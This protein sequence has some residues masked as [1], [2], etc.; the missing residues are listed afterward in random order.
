MPTGIQRTAKDV[1]DQAIRENKSVER[2]LYV[3]CSA[4]TGIGLF[5]LVLAAVQRQPIVA[6]ASSIP[7]SL[8]W[9]AIRFTK[10]T[11]KENIAL[12]LLEVPLSRAQTATAAAET[13]KH[14]FLDIFLGQRVTGPQAT[15]SKD[16]AGGEAASGESRI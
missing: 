9:P 8:L 12:R 6:L 1:I 11:R 13:L 15:D 10:D 16:L 7:I 5:V 14:L 2:L 4:A 3:L